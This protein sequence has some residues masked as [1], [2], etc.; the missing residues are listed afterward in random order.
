MLHVVEGVGKIVL[1]DVPRKLVHKW[2][3][4]KLSPTINGV[5]WGCNPCI[6]HA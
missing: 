6:N 2:F 1:K 3:I 5:Y 4:N